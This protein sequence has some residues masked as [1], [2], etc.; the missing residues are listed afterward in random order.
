MTENSSSMLQRDNERVGISRRNLLL[1]AAQTAG[2]GVLCLAGRGDSAP[3]KGQV[4]IATVSANYRE[5]LEQ[6]ARDYEKQ[7]PGVQV[8][9]QILPSNGYETWL[10]TQIPGGGDNAPD[11]FNANYAWGMYERG[12]LVNLSP[13]IAQKNP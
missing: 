9:V 10:R 12:L 1:A 6:V 3:R 2:V 5:G 8:K 13:F 7:N 11:L 4:T